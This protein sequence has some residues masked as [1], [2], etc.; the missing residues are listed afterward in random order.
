LVSLPSAAD[1]QVREL[2]NPLDEEN[3]AITLSIEFMVTWQL[4]APV[5][6]PPQPLKVAPPVGVA[7]NVTGVPP[8]KSAVQTEGQLIPVG[9]L[10]TVPLPETLTMRASMPNCGNVAVTLSA[11]LIVTVQL[12]LPLQAPPQPLKFMPAAGIAS[13]VT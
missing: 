13:S 6:A 4:T 12:P 5:Q 10:V 7:V 11:A 1:T 2:G 8:A 9:E 3:C